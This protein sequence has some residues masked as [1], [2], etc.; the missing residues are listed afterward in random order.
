MIALFLGVS[1]GSIYYVSQNKNETAQEATD[2]T[3]ESNP[4]AGPFSAAYYETILSTNDP[5]SHPEPFSASYYDQ[6][7]GANPTVATATT[8]AEIM[9]PTP[10]TPTA[11]ASP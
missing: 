2:L 1:I 11:G 3:T 7:N 10:L 5:A 6:Q 4:A 9:Y 8:S